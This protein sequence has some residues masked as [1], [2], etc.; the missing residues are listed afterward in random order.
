MEK[1]PKND[2]RTMRFFPTFKMLSQHTVKSPTY[3]LYA[4]S[5]I[6]KPRQTL[7]DV[8]W[9]FKF[10]TVLVA[11]CFTFDFVDFWT[12]EFFHN[13]LTMKLTVCCYGNICS[14]DYH[15]PTILTPRRWEYVWRV[16]SVDATENGADWKWPMELEARFWYTC[17]W[18]RWMFRKQNE[19][20]GY[21]IYVSRW[22]R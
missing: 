22:S 8:I 4:S 1:Q 11:N 9:I 17:T 20:D 15:P 18:E 16:H 2:E 19:M 14:P 13:F 6:L 21:Y 7:K 5:W 12:I 10:A 3:I